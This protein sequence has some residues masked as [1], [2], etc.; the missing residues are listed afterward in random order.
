MVEG[1][2]VLGEQPL[3]SRNADDGDTTRPQ[4]SG[5][6]GYRSRIILDVLEHIRGDD[7]IECS[8]SKR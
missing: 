6:F 5:D 7:R 8:A 2:V 1:G 4:N 3:V